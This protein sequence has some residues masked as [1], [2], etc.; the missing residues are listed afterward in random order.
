MLGLAVLVLL[1]ASDRV[2]PWGPVYTVGDD[3]QWTADGSRYVSNAGVL[4][5]A[6]G[7]STAFPSHCLAR[8]VLSVSPS[9]EILARCLTEI[10]VWSADLESVDRSDPECLS[11]PSQ[12]AWT[13]GA[14]AIPAGRDTVWIHGEGCQAAKKRLRTGRSPGTEAKVESGAVWVRDRRVGGIPW[15][16]ST[17]RRA[18]LAPGDSHLAVAHRVAAIRDGPGLVLRQDG[19][20]APPTEEEDG[21]R[22]VVEGDWTLRSPPESDEWVPIARLQGA[23]RSVGRGTGLGDTSVWHLSADDELV[24]WHLPGGVYSTAWTWD[25]DGRLLLFIRRDDGDDHWYELLRWTPG[26]DSFERLIEALGPVGPKAL[27]AGSGDRVAWRVGSEI[28]TWTFGEEVK[29]VRV[30]GMLRTGWHKHGVRVDTKEKRL[31]VSWDGTRS[32]TED[33][34]LPEEEKSETT[35]RAPMYQEQVGRWWAEW[36]RDLTLVWDMER[37]EAPARLPGRVVQMSD[38]WIIVATAD[39]LQSWAPDSDGELAPTASHAIGR[40]ASWTFTG[41]EMAV[42]D[43]GTVELLDPIALTTRR[44]LPSRLRTLSAVVEAGHGT[45]LVGKKGV[46]V[47]QGDEVVFRLSGSEVALSADLR[48]VAQMVGGELQVRQLDAPDEV[49]VLSREA[50]LAPLRFD[51]GLLQAGRGISTRAWEVGT[52]QPATPS[53]VASVPSRSK[54]GRALVDGERGVGLLAF[55][56]GWAVLHA[57][58]RLEGEDPEGRLIVS[59]LNGDRPAFRDQKIAVAADTRD[60]VLVPA[61]QSQG[62]GCSSWPRRGKGPLLLVALPLLGVRRR[63]Q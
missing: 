36:S 54:R 38:E 42:L 24:V 57:D 60:A 47:V 62:V 31:L 13:E 19:P 41:R 9:G 5:V 35:W 20:G 34:A 48:H 63:M 30:G 21:T 45:G 59:G 61:S 18:M 58:G 11:T 8:K 25:A 55:S 50:G 49:I 7:T 16:L 27:Y 44:T 1:G 43:G 14:F 51:D 52:W 6:T 32:R 17:H 28:H 56:G 3:G 40:R 39:Q 2:A 26:G 53:P 22:L 23:S 10:E 4:D 37:L 33:E 15:L 12:G 46:E 29:R